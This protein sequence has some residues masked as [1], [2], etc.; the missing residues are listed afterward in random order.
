MAECP[1]KRELEI[2]REEVNSAAQFLYGSLAV[3]SLAND[4]SVLKRLNIAPLFW[5]TVNFSLQKSCVLALGRVFQTDTPHNAASVMREAGQIDIF[6]K[7]ALRSRKCEQSPNAAE[8]IDDYMAHAYEPTHDDIRRLRKEER[9]GAGS[10][11]RT[12]SRFV[13]R[14]SHIECSPRAVRSWTH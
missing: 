13:T 1:F 2:F 6:F 11:R 14:R 9:V 7:Q 12:I 5:N 8:W 3:G 10:M 4:A